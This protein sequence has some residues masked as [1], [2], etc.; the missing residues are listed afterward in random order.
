MDALE[1]SWVCALCTKVRKLI[2]VDLKNTFFLFLPT[3]KKNPCF[4][5]CNHACFELLH[6]YQLRQF[7]LAHPKEIEPFPPL[8]LNSHHGAGM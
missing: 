1:I 2:T 3:P 5:F 7:S 6:K 8:L 4:N